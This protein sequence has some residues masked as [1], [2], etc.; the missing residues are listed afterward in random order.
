[1]V[2]RHRGTDSPTWSYSSRAPEKGTG[3]SELT[4][5]PHGQCGRCIGVPNS[6]TT[7]WIIKLVPVISQSSKNAPLCI[8]HRGKESGVH[9][10]LGQ[11]NRQRL[12]P[13]LGNVIHEFRVKLQRVVKILPTRFAFASQLCMEIMVA[14]SHAS[15]MQIQC[16]TNL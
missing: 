5:C 13:M 6:S 3:I 11:V 1:M 8:I 16:S 14:E 15:S 7:L 9:I 4:V 2:R 12:I 10:F